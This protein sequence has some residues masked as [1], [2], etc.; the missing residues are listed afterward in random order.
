MS[1]L[2]NIENMEA[3][4]RTIESMNKFHQIE[5]LK[6]LSKDLCKI[7]ENKS[8]CYINMSFLSN[9]TLYKIKEY[10]DYTQVQEETINNMESQKEEFKNAFFIGKDNKD[11]TPLLYTSLAK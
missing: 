8:G 7:N 5:I 6:I 9:E 11:E 2:Q 4:K 10:I 1:G 3:I